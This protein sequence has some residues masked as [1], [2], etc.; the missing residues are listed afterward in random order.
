MTMRNLQHV[1][2]DAKAPHVCG[3]WNELIVDDFRS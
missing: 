1:S 2:D 3:E